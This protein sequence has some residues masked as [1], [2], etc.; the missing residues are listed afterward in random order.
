MSSKSK[1][2]R[3]TV[4]V[5]GENFTGKT[6]SYTFKMV[7][8]RR[9]LELFHE[10]INGIIQFCGTVEEFLG[11]AKD[12]GMVAVAPSMCFE[13]KDFK[14][15][16]EE[17]MGGLEIDGGEVSAGDPFEFY[18]ALFHSLKKHFG[19]TLDPILMSFQERDKVDDSSSS[20]SPSQKTETPK[21]SD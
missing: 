2:V 8:T 14:V 21:D 5:E 1:S 15:I 9:G 7:G 3:K 18:A 20:Q 10:H 4:T 6:R 16:T 17:F 19:A 12:A 13:P 11:G